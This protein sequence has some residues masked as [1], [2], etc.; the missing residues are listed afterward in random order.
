VGE[1]GDTTKSQGQTVDAARVPE[2]SLAADL[3]QSAK[4]SFLQK[5][6]DG[7]RQLANQAGAHI[8]ARDLVDKPTT[9]TST[10]HKIAQEIGA[11]IGQLP[12]LLA[13]YAGT[14][15]ALGRFSE[16]ATSSFGIACRENLTANSLALSGATYNGLTTV[17]RDGHFNSD[18][19]NSAIVGGLTMYAIGKTQLGFQN[20]AGLAGREMSA[21]LLTNLGQR[22]ANAGFGALSGSVGGFVNAESS[23]L[24]FKRHP[25]SI[26]EVTSSMAKY[27]T[28]GFIFSGLPKSPEEQSSSAG[29]TGMSRA[30]RGYA[31]MSHPYVKINPK[32]VILDGNEE[33]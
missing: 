27:G 1:I 11:G 24:L 10:S 14:K 9:P 7:L 25:A 33:R 3:W 19:M 31:E 16:G 15:G 32:T 8:E 12:A 29:Y 6:Y 18:R 2:P 5:P 28:F 26:P 21:D 23:S 4:Y 30:P 22:A 17:S 13:L 20:A